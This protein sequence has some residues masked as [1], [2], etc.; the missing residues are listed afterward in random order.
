MESGY[1]GQQIRVTIRLFG[2]NLWIAHELAM[3][4]PNGHLL[5]G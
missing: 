2:R 1:D 3:C 5:A 4:N